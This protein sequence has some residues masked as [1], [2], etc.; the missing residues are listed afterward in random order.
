MYI[1]RNRLL[2]HACWVSKNWIKTFF[3]KV[4]ETQRGE[5]CGVAMLSGVTNYYYSGGPS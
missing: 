2:E 5:L 3:V 1:S 4:V